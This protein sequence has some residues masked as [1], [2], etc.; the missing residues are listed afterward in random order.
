MFLCCAL[1]LSLIHS[2]NRMESL[3]FSKQIELF[4]FSKFSIRSHPSESAC[5]RFYKIFI[6][7]TKSAKKKRIVEEAL[8]QISKIVLSPFCCCAFVFVR[9]NEFQLSKIAMDR[10]SNLSFPCETSIRT[11][12]F[13]KTMKSSSCSRSG[14]H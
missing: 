3:F 10:K 9:L 4:L 8:R 5:F 6:S 7:Q 1:S 2:C 11:Y 13:V 12:K 14:T